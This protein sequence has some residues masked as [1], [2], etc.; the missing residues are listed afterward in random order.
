MLRVTVHDAFGEA[1]DA[2][3]DVSGAYRKRVA[4]ECA[5]FGCRLV[6]RTGDTY[7]NVLAAER[8]VE[9]SWRGVPVFSGYL[10]RPAV[11]HGDEGDVYELLAYSAEVV[12]GE[13][14]TGTRSFLD[15]YG[16]EVL[17]GWEGDTELSADIAEPG[18]L[19]LSS[20]DGADTQRM[21]IL[22]RSGPFVLSERLR[23]E[24]TAPVSTANS[25][26]SLLYAE[27]E[28][29]AEGT[30]TVADAG[31][32]PVG[33]IGPGD[34]SLYRTDSRG[35]H[36][37]GVMYGQGFALS[38]ARPM[39][40]RIANL[41]VINEPP[42]VTMARVEEMGDTDPETG[43]AVEWTHALDPDTATI[44]LMPKAATGTVWQKW[45]DVTVRYEG[46]VS[47]CNAVILKGAK[48]ADAFGVPREVVGYA[49]LDDG[50]RTRIYRAQ[51]T[52]VKTAEDA[53]QKAAALLSELAQEDRWA[54]AEVPLEPC[55]A[56]YDA[57]RVFDPPAY[58]WADETVFEAEDDFDALVTTLRV[59]HRMPRFVSVTTLTG[60]ENVAI[61]GSVGVDSSLRP[62]TDTHD[63]AGNIAPERD[64]SVR[65]EVA[66]EGV[67]RARLR[68]CG[69]KYLQSSAGSHA[70]DA[71]SSFTFDAHEHGTGTLAGDSHSHGDGSYGTA[72][73]AHGSSTYAAASHPHTVYY[74]KHDVASSG[75]THSAS[76]TTGTSSISSTASGGD[77]NHPGTTTA[78]VANGNHFHGITGS[79]TT[80]DG[81]HGHT[82]ATSTSTDGAH[83]HGMSHTHSF[84]ATTGQTLSHA[85]AVYNI[86]S[87]T[88]S[89]SPGVSGSSD[90]KSP[91]VSGSSGGSGVTVGGSTGTRGGSISGTSGGTTAQPGLREVDSYPDGLTGAS[92]GI[93]R[94]AELGG[95]WGDGSTAFELDLDVTDW[96]QADGSYTLSFASGD[97]GRLE[98]YVAISY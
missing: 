8:A 77:H 57:V 64:L 94:T 19:S 79:Q 53:A 38:F 25:Y 17:Q 96:V 24:G 48:V 30:V 40:H 63:F 50:R 66:S 36:S 29:A 71:G 4:G 45:G 18:P 52:S 76:G 82:A 59:G 51:D 86:Q 91:D 2:T 56:L 35:N 12:L 39:T 97:D 93:D 42:V 90:S 28:A 47:S 74:Q 6:D 1:V 32:N 43:A 83:T 87:S 10:E 95:P 16:H 61:Y 21:N 78:I 60:L 7:R 34:A 89:Q 27:L 14:D 37:N 65:F 69:M 70:H 41:P 62:K 68:V 3:P 20:S 11:S 44:T 55:I 67:V 22:G 88:S 92:N 85:D 46:A 84:S 23:L 58:A 81:S 75:H 98:G 15:R 80:T 49:S 73:H 72:S 33:V 9:A 54:D 5:E 13:G 26:D 31:S